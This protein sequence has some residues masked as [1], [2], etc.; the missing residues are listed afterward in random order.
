M[1]TQTKA[2]TIKQWLKTTLMA[3]LA[4]LIPEL[5]VRYAPKIE[6]ISVNGTPQTISNKNVDITIDDTGNNKKMADVLEFALSNDTVYIGQQTEDSLSSYN[7][8]EYINNNLLTYS[9]SGYYSNTNFL[10]WS[11]PI[12]TTIS[13]GTWNNYGDGGER[14][15]KT[16]VTAIL[17][18]NSS[19]T[20]TVTFFA[21]LPAPAGLIFAA[22]INPENYD[23]YIDTGLGPN[24]NVEF[25]ATGYVQNGGM[26]V[27]VGM[28]YTTTDRTTLRLLSVSN[29]AQAGWAV[30]SE[31][32]YDATGI[33]VRKMLSYRQNY[34]ECV[35]SQEGL[36][37]TLTNDK[38]KSTFSTSFD[39]HIL[40]F[41]E[42]VTI[43]GGGF[44]G[45]RGGVIKEVKIRTLGTSP[46]D[47]DRIFVPAKLVSGEIVMLNLAFDSSL[48]DL[49][50]ANDFTAINQ[51][52][53]N[54]DFEIGGIYE[55]AVYRP[56]GTGTLVEVSESEYNQYL[57]TI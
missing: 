20:T 30:L 24:G 38:W 57:Q 5:D 9:S 19:L 27:L 26:G 8:E 44:G 18:D 45:Y 46:T 17:P 1:P 10:K 21:S 47:Y 32:T 35:L 11:P 29:K 56:S 31:A 33:N 7:I 41:D 2:E 25:E 4:R 43:S 12:T 14:Y 48:K 28:F 49:Y 37:H 6:S 23:A 50:L 53:A 13:T 36:T 54:G 15:N 22:K 34:Q 40:L 16:D 3:T 52:L 55:D 39:N 42:N 51:M